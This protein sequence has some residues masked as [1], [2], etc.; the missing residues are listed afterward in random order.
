L[1]NEVG[2]LFV[3]LKY[4]RDIVVKSSRSMSS[5]LYRFQLLLILHVT[6]GSDVATAMFVCYDVLPET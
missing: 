4:V 2:S 6:L 1:L 5:C 3:F